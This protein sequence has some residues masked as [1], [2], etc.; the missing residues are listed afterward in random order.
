MEFWIVRRGDGM[1]AIQEK[2][3]GFMTHYWKEIELA[4]TIDAVKVKLE[5]RR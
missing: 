4:A 1:L 3:W 2:K 5:N